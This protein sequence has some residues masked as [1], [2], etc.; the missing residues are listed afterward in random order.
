[1]SRAGYRRSLG[2]NWCEGGGGDPE[3]RALCRNAAR[4]RVR[5]RGVPYGAA[6]YA[7]TSESPT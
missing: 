2:I 3:G 5:G 6:P 1:M 7:W 4:R